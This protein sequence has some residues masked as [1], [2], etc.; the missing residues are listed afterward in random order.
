MPGMTRT[1]SPRPPVDHPDFPVAD[2]PVEAV[3][4]PSREVRA[5][6][7]SDDEDEEDENDGLNKLIQNELRSL[8]ISESGKPLLVM[9]RGLSFKYCFK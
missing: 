8:C 4:V 7:D 3:D 1:R 2:E 9:V 6:M 5:S